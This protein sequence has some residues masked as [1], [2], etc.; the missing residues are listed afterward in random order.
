MKVITTKQK[1]DNF[2][3]G[4]R[5]SPY[6]V[7]GSEGLGFLLEGCDSDQSVVYC[8]RIYRKKRTHKNFCCKSK[9]AGVFT[10]KT[11]FNLSNL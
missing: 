5:L 11:T 2:T 9:E 8:F 7:A 4:C 1:Y 10:V 6:I 3:A